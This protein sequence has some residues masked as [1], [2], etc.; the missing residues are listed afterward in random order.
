MCGR[1]SLAV[2]MGVLMERFDAEPADGVSIQP[3]YNLAPRDDLVVIQNDAPKEMDLLQWGFLP[4]WADSPDATPRPINAR[5]ETAAEKPMFRDAFENR[6]CLILADGFYEWKGQRGSKQPYRIE[7]TD[8]EP[9][10]YAGLWETWSQSDETLA[11]CTILTCDANEV[12]GQVHDRMPVML[13][14][15]AEREWLNGADVEELNELLKPYPDDELRAY[16][17]SKRI[18]N[19]NNDS[20]ELIEEIDIGEQSGLGEFGA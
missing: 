7:R 10:A 15:E 1:T 9:Y 2:A 3:R 16:P 13:T 19:P 18:N 17:I 4:Q 14:Q 20:A 12:V 8:Q 11:T 5:S 6:R